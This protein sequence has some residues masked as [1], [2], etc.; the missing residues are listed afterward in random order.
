[1]ATVFVIYCADSPIEKQISYT[2]SIGDD[3]GLQGA[4][5]KC[6]TTTNNFSR[7]II[8]YT[9]L[10]AKMST[11]TCIYKVLSRFLSTNFM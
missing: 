6:T 1:M 3:I 9:V 10:C 4:S 2:S 7:V 8:L 11:I 5:E